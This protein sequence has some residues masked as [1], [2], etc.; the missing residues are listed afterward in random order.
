[1]VKCAWYDDVSA[2][3]TVEVVLSIRVSVQRLTT[4]TTG[5][6]EHVEQWTYRSSS[7]YPVY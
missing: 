2:W 1:M 5:Y 7:P 6:R 4:S 3:A